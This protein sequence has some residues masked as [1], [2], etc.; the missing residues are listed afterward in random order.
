MRRLLTLVLLILATPSFAQ[1]WGQMATISSTMGIQGNHLCMGETSR[2]DIGCPAYAPSVATNGTLTATKFIGDGSQLT[3]L[4]LPNTATDRIST[5]GI[6]SGANLGMVVADRGTVSFTLAGTQGAAYLHATAGLVGPAISTTTGNVQTLRVLNSTTGE[7]AATP[8][9]SWSGDPN[10]GIFWLG[11]NSFGFSTAGAERMRITPS[12]RLAIGTTL[13]SGT[14]TI[15]G[16]SWPDVYIEETS[17]GAA[18]QIQLAN[19]ARTWDIGADSSPDIF[20]IGPVI[21]PATASVN[22]ATFAITSNGNVGISTTAPSEKLEVVGNVKATAFIGDGSQLTGINTGL[23]D[24]IVSGTNYVQTS[25]NGIVHITNS[26]NGTVAVEVGSG[27]TANRTTYI[28]LT[29]DATYSDY[30]LRIIRNNGGANTTSQIIHRGTGNFTIGTT[31]AANLVFNTGNAQRALLNASGLTV[32]GYVSTTGIIDAGAAIY[33]YAGDSVSA[34]GYTWSGDTNT[35]M[36]WAAAD[37]LGFATGGTQRALLN[38]AGLYVTGGLYTGGRLAVTS[39]NSVH[40]TYYPDDT[41]Y[42]Y[43]AGYNNSGQRGFY[44]GYGNGGTQ[45]NL[46]LDNATTL[47]MSGGT[48]NMSSQKIIGVISPTA[49]TEVANKQ[50]VDMAV[51]SGGADNLGDHTATTTLKATNGTAALPAYTFTGDTNTGIY[52]PAT[53][54]LGLSAGGTQRVL[55]NS[56]GIT[57]TGAIVSKPYNAGSSTSID[58]SRAN[59]QYTTTS[60]SAFTFSNMV[61]GGSYTLA[62]QGS[63]SAVCSFSHSGLTFRLPPDHGA[64][65]A[66]THTL[67]SFVRMGT[68]VYVTWLRNM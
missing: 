12:G 24:R 60:C 8:G 4:T 65:V 51:A 26:S 22:Q 28:D 5:T 21:D 48:L 45:V 54:Q 53:D 15:K 42:G 52:W 68:T 41:H 63:T 19:T 50:Y 67:Y 58:W 9:F 13:A 18:A 7:A 33:G 17:A 25:S 43:F 62:V 27:A 56:D 47:A 31:E 30:G 32:T 16:A 38:S 29:G 37:Q 57:V 1:D 49:N 2:G 14:L 39:N 11:E 6:A 23:A 40:T 61:D 36:Y 35:G 46:V 34:P 20:S 10:T 59:M 64:T 66:S 44:L 55:V 3:N